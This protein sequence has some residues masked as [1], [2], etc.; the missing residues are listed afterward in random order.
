[1][2]T[3]AQITTISII[4]VKK[5]IQ[6]KKKQP[7]I[8][9]IAEEL[10]IAFSTVSRALQDN[11]RIGLKTREKVWEIAKKINY[12]PNPAAMFLK[13][14]KTLSIG[15]LIPSLNEEFFTHAITGVENVIEEK[16]YHSVIIQSRETLERELKA[17]DTFLKMRIDGLIVSISAETNNFSHFKKLESFGIPIVFF[18]RVPSQAGFN[19]VI[20]NTID[21]AAQAVDLL[22]EKGCKNIGILNGP[23]N[24]QASQDRLSGY[25][26]GLKKNNIQIIESLIKNCDLTKEEAIDKTKEML[27]GPDIPDAIIT[28]NDY[29]AMYAMIEC[30]SEGYFPNKDILIVGFGNLPFTNYLENP[31]FASIEQYPTQIGSSAARLLLETMDN[32]QETMIYKEITIQTNLI[33]HEIAYLV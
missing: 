24:L 28:F 4:F 22:V 5:T 9:D 31:P 15:I 11:P 3:F 8:K 30:K 18:D 17:I 14:N 1:M 21:G 33:V 26:I 32:N 16:G 7:T 12:I 10:G 25:I 13:N 29:L 27:N 2:Q 20:C 23:K 6:M 19:K